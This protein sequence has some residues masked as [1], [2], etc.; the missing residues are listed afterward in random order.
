MPPILRG[1]DLSVLLRSFL[2]HHERRHRPR[3]PGG[4][5]AQLIVSVEARDVAVSTEPDETLADRLER[6]AENELEADDER[7]AIQE[8]NQEYEDHGLLP[9]AQDDHHYGVD[10]DAERI[11]VNDFYAYLPAHQYIFV[12]TRE[13]WPASGVNAKCPTSL[14][15]NGQP[16]TKV[17][18]RKG[19]GGVTTFES[20]P[21]PPTQYLDEHRAVDQMTWAPGEPMI[22]ANRLVDGGGWIERQGVNCFNL[23]RPPDR[24][25]GDPGAA[26]RWLDHLSRVFPDNAEHILCWLA[27]RV[28]KPGEKINHALVLGGAQGIGKD[29]ILEPIKYAIGPWNFGEVSPAHL[30]GRFNGWVKNVILR[31]SEARDLGDVDRYSFYDHTKT[32][33]AAPPDVLHCDEKNLREHAVMNVMGMIITTNHKTDGIYLPAD[34]R[35][36][37]VAWSTIT[38]DAFSDTYWRSLYGWFRSGG[39]RHVTAHLAGL[40]LSGFDPKAPPPHTAAFWDIV[41]ANRAPEDAELAD[42]LEVLGNPAALTLCDIMTSVPEDFRQ[43]LQ[44]RRNRRLIPHRLDTAGYAQVRNN[45]ATDGLWRVGGKRGVIYVLKKLSVRDQIAAA[46]ALV[47]GG[48]R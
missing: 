32:F 46:T 43:W 12:P 1:T 10:G 24:R 30:L 8:I 31:V 48:R 19:K 38:K 4:N 15:E 39:S 7:S 2:H 22:I 44:D 45:G 11:S 6:W 16:I 36:H 5:L 20:V 17:V 37:Y 18:P 14:G 29:T 42:A 41:D 9:D 25:Q 35:R 28:Q 3:D 26:T 27:H 33:T 23:Y 40:D 34:D 21:V 47:S 13:L